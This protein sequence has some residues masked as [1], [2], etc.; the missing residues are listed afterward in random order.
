MKNDIRR[1]RE[2]SSEHVYPRASD[3]NEKR[4]QTSDQHGNK[5]EP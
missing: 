4:H 5:S 3:D 1:G 2:E